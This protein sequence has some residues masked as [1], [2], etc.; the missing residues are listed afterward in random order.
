MRGAKSKHILEAVKYGICGALSTI[1]DI[2]IFWFLANVL[3]LYYLIANAIAW[4]VAL[5][6]SFLANKYYVFESKSFKKEVWLKE[7]AEFFGARGLAC[8]MDMG[9]MYL[10]VSIIEINQNYAKLIVTLIVIIINY[11]FSK[12]WIFKKSIDG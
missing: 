10:L 6:F 3:N 12:F 1:L 11:I 4:I 5:I 9:G 7:A 2:G 8:G